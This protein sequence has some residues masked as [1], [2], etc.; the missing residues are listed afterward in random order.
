MT[1]TDAS[2]EFIH[3]EQAHPVP[4]VL[5]DEVHITPRGDFLHCLLLD[6]GELA[7]TCGGLDV[8]RE[9]ASAVD[10]DRGAIGRRLTD[11]QTAEVLEG[12]L[13]GPVDESVPRGPSRRTRG[14]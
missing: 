4:E 8:R 2:V 1:Y 10:R 9:A 5:Y 7:I 14:A 6:E 12:S 3:F 13:G 11:R